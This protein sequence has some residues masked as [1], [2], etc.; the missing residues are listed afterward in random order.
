M[1]VFTSKEQIV[2]QMRLNLAK[3]PSVRARAVVR[4]FQNQ[5]KDEQSTESTNH[6]NKIGFTGSDAHFLTSL[7][8]QYI[9]KGYLSQKQDAVLARKITKYARQLVNGSI[10]EGKI[11]EHGGRYYTNESV[12]VLRSRIANNGRADFDGV[13]E[14]IY[15]S[16]KF[17][18][19]ERQQEAAAYLAMKD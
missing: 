9:R 10:A 15:W 1:A 16:N 18:E 8:K 6:Y 12:A 3:S 4:I 5:T 19:L 11:V 13:A 2:A 17:G 14:D 7:A